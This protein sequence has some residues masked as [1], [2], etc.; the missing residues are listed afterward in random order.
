MGG[1]VSE[2]P[3]RIREWDKV[4]QRERRPGKGITFEM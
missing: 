2:H 4:F 3:H 1:W